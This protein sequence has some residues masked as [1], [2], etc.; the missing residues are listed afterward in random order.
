ML[1][2]VMVFVCL[3][4]LTVTAAFAQSRACGTMEY[5]QQLEKNRPGLRAQLQQQ[6]RNVNRLD[7]KLLDGKPVLGQVV[8]IPVVVHVV[9][10]TAAQNITEAQIQSQLAVLNKDFRRLNADASKTPSMFQGVAADAEI[11]FC[12]AKQDPDGE[13]TNGI[14][15]TSTT[16]KK[17]GGLTDSMKFDG[18]GGK[19]AWDS[20]KYLNI[21]VVNF[22]NDANILGFAQFPNSGPAATD[23]VVIDFQS[24]GTTGTVLRPYNLGRTTTHEVGHWLNLFHIWGDESCG[25]DAVSDTPTQEEENNGCPTF[26]K[27]SCSN[28]SDMFMNYM[29][30]TDDICMNLFTQGQKTVMQSM[31][32]SYRSGLLSSKGCVAPEVPALDG[33][34]LGF[35]V[36]SGTLCTNTLAPVV[37]LRNRGSGALTNVQFQ[38][39]VDNEVAQTFT[40]TGNLGSFQTQEVTLPTQQVASGP[41]V[42]TVTILASN[43]QTLDGNPSNNTATVSLQ[44]QGSALPLREGFESATFPPAGWSINNVQQDLT[45]QQT[46]KAAFSGTNS[47]FMQNIEYPANGPVDELVMPALDLTSRSAPRLTFQL[48]YSLLSSSGYSDTLEVQ[49]ST[50]CGKTFQQVYKK[51]GRALTTVSPYYREEE[52]V[53][54]GAAQWRLESIDLSAYATVKTAIIKFRHTTD[55]ENNLYLDDVKVDGNA[56][57][58]A[59]ERIL[60]AVQVAPNPT[61]GVVQITSPEVAITAVQ[62]L[63][64][65]GKEI[66][67]IQVSRT[68]KGQALQV[69]LGG[70][71]NGV[72]LL[73]LTSEK[74]VTVR[75]VVL[76]K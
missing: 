57:G 32:N 7:Y 37:Y 12:L 3:W 49:I 4:G 51:F 70:L 74:G 19:S 58:T 47:V 31:F 17:F 25:D 44:V 48:A 50:D 68:A 65:L 24:F 14:T 54:T 10:N 53:P 29:D 52:F 6:A 69:N 75:R 40:W 8:S 22:D 56:L 13:P 9:Y 33:A 41:H 26:P 15:R 59:E 23:G 42:V 64:A 71:S 34:L 60:Q 27:A 38:I 21:W 63:D 16:V 36:P 76:A 61:S 67:T 39:K 55:Y 1:N 11:E 46:T 45:W 28:T 5:V 35:K 43:G 66:Q 18:L 2:K 20:K 73:R 72:Y 62:V 30:Y